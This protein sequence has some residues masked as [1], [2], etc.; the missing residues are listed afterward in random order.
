[1]KSKRHQKR[2]KKFKK[3]ART[4]RRVRRGGDSR[5]AA[6]NTWR[7]NLDA[8]LHPENP[9]LVEKA[10]T[11]SQ[12]YEQ[13]MAS[14]ND[15]EMKHWNDNWKVYRERAR[16]RSLEELEQF[17][18]KQ[19]NAHISIP[20]II[21]HRELKLIKQ[22]TLTVA[23]YIGFYPV[24]YLDA[25]GKFAGIDVEVITEFAKVAGLKVKFNKIDHFD[26]IWLNVSDG[27][28]DIAIGGIANLPE[29]SNVFIEWTIPYF[30]V[31]RSAMFKTENP[32]RLPFP[33]GLNGILVGTKGS[34]GWLDGE[35]RLAKVGKQKQMEEGA[36][37]DKGND[38]DI[39]RLEKGEIQG[40]MR[41]DL[42]SR[43]IIKKHPSLH[44][45]S[46]DM[47]KNEKMPKDG[48]VFAYPTRA[49]SNLSVTMS[50]FITWLIDNN[51]LSALMR[52][53]ELLEK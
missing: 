34:T 42:V 24:C 17:G 41:G 9:S 43:A 15:A 11:S 52:K 6:L 37:G 20:F 49:G 47:E 25:N 21:N 30:Y 19:D 12:A 53:Y 40:V 27:N 1:M 31:H 3:K 18:D 2:S 14:E 8:Y 44:M 26:N 5:P 16:P 13:E 45:I 23:A 39:E 50:A 35:A 7:N 10:D 29:R 33:E 51:I 4:A 28:A 36:S 46:W 48:E 32:L 38:Q 22:D